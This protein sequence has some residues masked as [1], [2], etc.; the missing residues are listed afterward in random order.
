MRKFLLAL[1]TASLSSALT[2]W[3]IDAHYSPFLLQRLPVYVINTQKKPLL[4][5]DANNIRAPAISLLQPN[6]GFRLFYA[7]D[8]GQWLYGLKNNRSVFLKNQD[9]LVAFVLYGRRFPISETWKFFSALTLFLLLLIFSYRCYSKSSNTQYPSRYSRNKRIYPT[10]SEQ[11][12]SPTPN[13]ENRWLRQENY[14]LTQKISRINQEK[15][16]F[17]RREQ[18]LFDVIHQTH[19]RAGVTVPDMQ[20]EYDALEKEY[21]EVS[22]RYKKLKND[23]KI[24][25]INFD[26]S[27]YESIIKGRKFEIYLARNLVENRTHEILE[28]TPDKGFDSSIRVKSNGN[29]DLVVQN[30]NGQ[31]FAIECKFRGTHFRT[32]EGQ[33]TD[34]VSWSSAYAA[35][36][37]QA[38]SAERGMPVFIALGW[39][40]LPE[41][42][43]RLFLAPLDG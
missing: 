12:P 18:R 2:A 17:I 37:Y 8:T 9:R 16:D 25:D 19:S 42:P 40:G 36:R 10:V 22:E 29:P 14:R 23:S 24:F 21:A 31:Q 3:I 28:W 6:D 32:I 33:Q 26:S 39:K 35:E 43:K 20:Y 38:F 13:H 41:S 34:Q 30:K 5:Y 11:K 15:E 1:V 7:G 4:L 27:S